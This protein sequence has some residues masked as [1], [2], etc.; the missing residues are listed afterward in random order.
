MKTLNP[1][2]MSYQSSNGQPQHGRWVFHTFVG[3]EKDPA[4]TLEVKLPHDY[5]GVEH[6][7][8]FFIF[9]D[10]IE[11]RVRTEEAHKQARQDVID[12]EGE[13]AEVSWEETNLSEGFCRS[14]WGW[15]FSDAV[16]DILRRWDAIQLIVNPAVTW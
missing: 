5:S 3:D 1:V 2:S 12:H 6:T 4:F 10:G 7:P 8:E 14:V 13:G 15:G 16:A 9:K 11:Y